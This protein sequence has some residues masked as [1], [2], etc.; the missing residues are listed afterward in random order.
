M[1]KS[2]SKDLDLSKKQTGRFEFTS[3]NWNKPVMAS[4]K[5]NHNLAGKASSQFVVTAGNIAFSW[6]VSLGVLGVVLLLIG[7]YNRIMLPRPLE[8]ENKEKIGWSVY[9]EVFVSF[10]TRPGIV[11]AL[12]FFLLYRLGES[13][14]V[15]VA[16]PFLVDS[17]SSG[18]IGMTSAQYG[19][20]YGTIGMLCLTMGG[21]LGGITAAKFGL[22]KLIW[23][24][25]LSMN[26]PIS[27]YIYLST[28]QPMPGDFTIYMAIALEQ[29]GYGFGFTAYMLYM[30]HFVGESKY[31][32]AEYAIGTSLMALGMMLPGMI[33]GSMK[34]LLGYQH[35]FIYVILCSIPGIIAI[36]F[37]R[38]DPGFGIKKKV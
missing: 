12:L 7:L 20:A 22:K 1:R 31:K 19:I 2:G 17:R 34:E 38:I 5:V 13:Q 18:G 9:K 33:S 21:I 14:L 6:V 30:L 35:F 36:K 16:T 37:L 29:F 11:P 25:A 27:V 23:F 26:I 32:T 3:T 15:K 24:M 28:F 8:N 4:I 10:F